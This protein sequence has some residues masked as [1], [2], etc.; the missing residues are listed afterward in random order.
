MRAALDVLLSPAELDALGQRDLGDTVC[1]VFDVLRAATTMLTALASG[2]EAIIPV[3]EI[4]QALAHRARR[5]DVLLAGERDGVRIRAALTGGVDFDLGNSPR[6]F[7]PERVA[8]RTIVMTT[9]N[10]T[11]ALEACAG[12]RATLVGSF[13][14]L[15]SLTDWIRARR[16]TRLL[17][18]C[19][20]TFDAVA[21][22]D[23][24]AAGAVCDA[25]WE[26]YAGGRIGD[27]AEIARAVHASF[28]P[29]VLAVMGRSRN[30]RKLLADTDLRDDVAFAARRDT[31]AFVAGRSPD[32]AIRRLPAS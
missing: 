32:G 15:R 11:R 22:E 23:V 12:A 19:S 26:V 14:N 31:L 8:G 18:V 28:A 27:A 24:L 2:A 1:V 10:G 7:T 4:A 21:L 6:E 20:G 3:A 17:L 16:G 9:T 25:V 13:L 5:P 29:D 30:G